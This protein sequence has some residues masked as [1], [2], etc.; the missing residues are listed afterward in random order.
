MSGFGLEIQG[1]IE[2]ALLELQDRASDLRPVGLDTA[3]LIQADV[4]E[5]FERS[6]STTT[7]GAIFGGGSWE[8]LTED[9]LKRRPERAFG[10]LLRDT[11]DLLGSFTVGGEGNLT[12]IDRTSV[13]FGS[14]LPKARGLQDKRPMIF[15]HDELVE[16]IER[17]WS[18]YIIG[19]LK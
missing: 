8:P 17:L 11:S 1:D 6:P 7:G 2:Q 3:L 14:T 19:D 13:E 16:S 9:Y 10:Q 15:P 12:E 4:D 18:D 5:R